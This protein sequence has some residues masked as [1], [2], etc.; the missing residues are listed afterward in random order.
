[1]NIGYLDDMADPTGKIGEDKDA[2]LSLKRNHPGLSVYLIVEGKFSA[3]VKDYAKS[4]GLSQ[5]KVT[6][7][8][9]EA[10]LDGIIVVKSKDTKETLKVLLSKYEQMNMVCNPFDVM[11][12]TRNRF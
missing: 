11:M 12:D 7:S 3:P 10:N 1:M 6:K 2:F 4:L 9:D 5:A 8:L